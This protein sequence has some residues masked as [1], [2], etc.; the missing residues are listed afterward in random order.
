MAAKR[1]V[2][3]VLLLAAL[4][5]GVSYATDP[6]S[7]APISGS[8]QQLASP[9]G[10]FKS[11]ARVVPNCPNVADGQ[12]DVS[13]V[14]VSPDGNFA[15]AASLYSSTIS[16]TGVA[17]TKPGGTITIY[18][19]NPTTGVLTDIGC[20]RDAGAPINP[21]TMPCTTSMPALRASKTITLSPDGRFMYVAALESDAVTVLARDADTGELSFVGCVQTTLEAPQVC[22]VTTKGLHGVRWVTVSSDGQNVYAAGSSADAI[23]E[24]SRDADTGMITPLPGA[25]SCIEDVHA[26][27]DTDCPS[28]A[29]GLNYPRTITVSPDGKNAYVASDHAD[30][31]YRDPNNPGN[32]DAVSEFSRDATT[33]ALKQLPAPN[34][35]IKDRQAVQ[36]SLTNCPV[37]KGLL[38]AF[39]VAVSPDGEYVYVGGSNNNKGTVAEFKRNT[40]T[41]A[42]TQ[43]AGKA[44]WLSGSTTCN[45]FS[46][47]TVVKPLL[48]GDA[49]TFAHDGA[50]AY[51]ASFHAIGQVV[52]FNRNATTGVLSFSSCVRDPRATAFTMCTPVTGYLAGPRIAY[53]SPDD[54]FVYVPSSVS[55]TLDSF[56]INP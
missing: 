17:S 4:Q 44:A 42:L 29:S 55:Y 12:Q 26:R 16:S 28:R 56:K 51:V 22:D 48:D 37:G 36:T 19:R 40:T 45:N 27:T 31:S 24:F 33:G 7:A 46:D 32:G 18:S 47:C 13:S 3:V 50:I 20:V 53:V 41:G 43:L 6:A 54:G 34:A 5:L 1:K 52:A 15:Y 38:G 23:A 11:L 8:L 35:C 49:M 21:V 9:D 25:D 2:A 39:H 10:C 30:S 14:V